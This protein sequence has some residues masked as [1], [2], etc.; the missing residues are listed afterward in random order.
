MAKMNLPNAFSS[1]NTH[2]IVMIPADPARGDF[3]R[4]EEL[5]ADG[6]EA[7]RDALDQMQALPSDVALALQPAERALR[8]ALDKRRLL[9]T[10]C[11]NA[12]RRWLD[13]AGRRKQ[14]HGVEPELSSIW[15]LLCEAELTAERVLDLLAAEKDVGWQRGVGR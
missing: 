7:M 3:E 4:L 6:F 10:E 14:T 5:V 11:R 9:S 1:A 12:I 13:E 8:Q 2:R 15:M